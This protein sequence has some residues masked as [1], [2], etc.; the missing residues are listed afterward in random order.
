MACALA[1]CFC[2]LVAGGAER[3][4]KRNAIALAELAERFDCSDVTFHVKNSTARE[5]RHSLKKYIYR[6]SA[7]RRSAR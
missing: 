5:Y 1:V 7:L 3:D 6:S 2:V 4:A